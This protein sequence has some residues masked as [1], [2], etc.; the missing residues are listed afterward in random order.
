MQTI[1][2]PIVDLPQ[3]P[4]LLDAM[5]QSSAIAIDTEFTRINTYN[6]IPQL[7]QIATDD[8]I[9]VVDVAQCPDLSALAAMLR[10]YRRDVVIHSAFQDMEILHLLQAMPQRIFDT[11][12]AAQLCGL[13]HMSYRK[14]LDVLLGVKIA[15]DM[16]RSDWSRRPV[17]GAQL[18]YAL[19]D[20]QY[21][22]PAYQKL[23]QQVEFLQRGAWMREEQEQLRQSFADSLSLDSAWIGFKGAERLAAADQHRVRALLLWRE[24]RARH[25]DRPRRWIMKDQHILQAVQSKPKTRAQLAQMLRLR[26]AKKRSWLDTV[27]AIIHSNSVP[28]PN[29]RIWQARARMTSA[30]TQQANLLHAKLNGLAQ[31]LSVSETLLCSRSDCR[32]IVRGVGSSRLCR[33]WRREI[34]Q[35]LIAEFES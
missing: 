27:L 15:K 25:H 32:A 33:G 7:L 31:Q 3:C 29:A 6:P 2:Q 30:Q 10:E 8:V 21:L 12:V 34:S 17:S 9:A 13:E 11:Q 28:P 16:S 22:L 35:E 24:K 19:D 18:A 5:C 1:S 23:M 4:Q 26:P 14:L 20:V